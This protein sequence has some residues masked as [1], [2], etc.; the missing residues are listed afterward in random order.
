[1]PILSKKHLG[2]EKDYLQETQMIGAALGGIMHIIFVFLFAHFDVPLLFWFNLL[3]SV[4]VFTTAFISSYLG[5]LKISP[6]IGTIEIT[7]HQV[8][9][10]LLLGSETGF[11]LLL[12]CLV[13]VGILFLK[14]KRAF[15][16]N[17]SIS[18][19]LFLAL[20]WFD[21]EQFIR[22]PL[23]ENAI[24]VMRLI[25]SIGLFMIVGLI[26]YYYISLN[27][28]LYIKQK[29]TSDSLYNVN[30]ELQATLEILHRQNKH[31]RESIEYAER[32]QSALLTPKAI[33]CD[34][35]EDY[36]ILFQPRDVISGDFYWSCCKDGKLLFVV[37]DCT[38]H[39]IPGAFLSALGI[40]FLNHITS[41]TRIMHANKLLEDLRD[42]VITSMHQTPSGKEARD[43]MEMALCI[44]DLQSGMLE[45]AGANR[46][47]YIVRKPVIKS[48]PTKKRSSPAH[49]LEQVNA[50]KMPIGIYEQENKPFNNHAIPL[51]KG[52]SF[53][54]FS[55]GYVDQLGGPHRKT[56][57]SANL[58]KLIWEIH[59]R[60]MY[61]QKEILKTRLSSWQGNVEQID[62]ILVMGIRI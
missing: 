9:A 56:F 42:H 15:F 39:G 1:M 52:D 40:S 16:I 23:P 4:P 34:Y 50:D 55:D 31:I 20:S 30:E 25:N 46:P 6:L 57:R 54:M 27:R 58:K 38:G 41:R 8:L 5:N 28:K 43:G 26:I 24:R 19:I 12:F 21:L 49:Y 35:L 44:L 48:L 11:S 22:Y 29:V 36:F 60:P 18:L 51:Q 17:S 32:I 3:F 10:A 62:D 45:F 61:L 47:I 53:Y 7:A 14:W 13:P 37:A 33:F 2:P 59:D